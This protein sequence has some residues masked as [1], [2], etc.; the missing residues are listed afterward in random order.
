M[1]ELDDILPPDIAYASSGPDGETTGTDLNA[2]KRQQVKDLFL[3]LINTSS[4]SWD[5]MTNLKE[6]R[7]K[8]EE[9]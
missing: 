2:H 6:L 9:L 8:V 5:A 4:S 7:K 1:S 3:E